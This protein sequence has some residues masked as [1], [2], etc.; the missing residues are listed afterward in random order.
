MFLYSK[1]AKD[2]YL[3]LNEYITSKIA[4]MGHDFNGLREKLNPPPGSTFRTKGETRKLQYIFNGSI[5]KTKDDVKKVLKLKKEQIEV[6]YV[7]YNEYIN[8]YIVSF[9]RK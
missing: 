7:I 4:E 5:V 1:K 9:V 3:F 6:L 2:G 8:T